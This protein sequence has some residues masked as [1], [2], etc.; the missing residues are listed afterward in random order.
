MKNQMSSME[1]LLL[2]HKSSSE[3]VDLS[4]A[5]RVVLSVILCHVNGELKNGYEAWPSTDILVSRTGMST[6]G[7]SK[8]RKALVDK[9]WMQVVSGRKKGVANHYFVNAE[10]I[11][12]TAA[13]GGITHFGKELAPTV[14]NSTQ[15]EQHERDVSGLKQG[16]V[17]PAAIKPTISKTPVLDWFDQDEEVVKEVHIKLQSN[18]DGSNPFHSNGKRCYSKADHTSFNQKRIE[19]INAGDEPF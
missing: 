8:S 5:E 9:G 17:Q 2:L 15:K 11:V 3:Y 13:K 16:K 10:K 7:I 12:A 6:T 14:L 19:E 18:S 1:L 4:L